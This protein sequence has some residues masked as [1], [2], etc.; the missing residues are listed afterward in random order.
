M[1][2]PPL[3]PH[4]FVYRFAYTMATSILHR[5]TG[6]FMAIGLA[7]LACW[8]MAAANGPESYG[9]VVAAYSNVIFLLLLLGWLASFLYHLV[10]GLRHLFLDAGIGMEKAQAR[11]SAALVVLLTLLALGGSLWL[12]S[13]HLGAAP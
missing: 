4:L 13:T 1:A 3:S 8:L 2:A 5:A 11:R 7:A 12:L 10:N 9:A 6:V